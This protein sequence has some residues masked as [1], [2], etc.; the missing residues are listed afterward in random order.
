MKFLL[1]SIFSFFFLNL[2]VLSGQKSGDN[3]FNNEVLHEINIEFDQ[4]N[5]W[6]ILSQNFENNFF[7]ATVPYLMGRVTIDG[8]LVDSVGVRFK[9]FTSYP[10]LHN[11]KPIK[12]DFNEY[13]SGQ[14]YDGLRKLN[15]NNA[16][17]DPAMQRDVVSYK[18][19]REMGVAAPRTSF[20]KVYFNGEYWG[21]YQNIEQVDKSFL[22]NNFANDNG[23]LFKNKGWSHL[24]WLGTAQSQ[25]NPPFE[26]RT[27]EIGDDWS[28]FI[29]FIDVL[30]NAPVSEF[31]EEISKVFNVDLF[32]KILAVDVATNNWDSYLEHGRNWYMYEDTVS[33]KFNWIP[34][35]Y[36]LALEGTLSFGGGDDF[37][38]P[39]FL[40]WESGT[41]T[42][43][44]LNFSQYSGDVEYEWDFGDGHFSSEKSPTHTYD[45]HGVYQVCLRVFNGTNAETTCMSVVT[46]NS[47]ENCNSLITGQTEHEPSV[48]LQAVMDWGPGCCNSWSADCEAFYED[49][50]SW[51]NGGSS[52][53]GFE[54]D[55]R[56]NEGVLIRRLLEVPEFYNMYYE[57]FCTLMNYVMN[58]ERIFATMDHNKELIA[59]SYEAEPHPLFSYSAFLDDMGGVDNNAGLKGYLSARINNLNVE[60]ES[61]FSCTV[62]TPIMAG[63]VVINEIVAANDSLSNVTDQAGDHDDW[64]EL[65]NPSSIEQDLSMTYLSDD[66][67]NLKK[68]EFPLGTVLAPNEYV[69]VW[70]DDDQE[71]EG[72][73]SSFKLSREG[74]QVYFSNADGTIIDSLNFGPQESNRGYARIPNGTGDF[75]IKGMTPGYN[76]EE[77]SNTDELL[78]DLAISI[79][80][81]PTSD[82]LHVKVE[83]SKSVVIEMFTITGQLIKRTAYGTNKIR[84]NVAH[85]DDGYYFI[86]ITT[87]EGHQHKRKFLVTH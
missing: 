40:Y 4:A 36:N 75:I 42:V 10:F 31:K 72:F 70:A 33:G 49:M 34:W 15:L 50:E 20:S 22:E 1:V 37:L 13:V 64:I 61:E 62:V 56:A 84:E 80:P 66:L 59:E 60:L 71:Q 9:G 3:M 79:Y 28:G 32:L 48:I 73:H 52:G 74:E 54:I 87:E 14:K 44:F 7:D 35:D 78:E 65:F 23:N 86:N 83:N 82:Y 53:D 8:E 11:K 55:Q 68:F 21:V 24:E 39:D 77:L 25:Y 58:E 30:N 67:A 63:E 43:E 41:T 16:T 81:N 17:G 26:L 27:N 85:L 2:S 47:I 6:Q 12:L 38:L 76:N 46:T 18:L 51:I 45:A 69:M 57:N 29:N 5:Y 19:L